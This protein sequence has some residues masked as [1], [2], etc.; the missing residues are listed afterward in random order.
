MQPRV[1]RQPVMAS[2]SAMP[3]YCHSAGSGVCPPVELNEAYAYRPERCSVQ[4]LL[5]GLNSQQIVDAESV[6]RLY[7]VYTDERCNLDCAYTNLQM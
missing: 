6:F 4:P 7:T 2:F 3:V 1:Q 5:R